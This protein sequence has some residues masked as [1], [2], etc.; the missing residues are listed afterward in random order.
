M[1]KCAQ[2]D[3]SCRRALKHLLFLI[4]IFFFSVLNFCNSTF[5]CCCPRH[6]EKGGLN[7]FWCFIRSHHIHVII[8]GSFDMFLFPQCFQKASSSK[9]FPRLGSPVCSNVLGWRTRGRWLNP[10]TSDFFRRIGDSQCNMIHLSL[11]LSLSH[12]HFI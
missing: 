1:C 8:Y 4:Q 3:L 2:Y 5:C 7:A 6:M 11:S 9:V 12:D 10:C